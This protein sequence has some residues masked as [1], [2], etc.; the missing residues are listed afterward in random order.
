MKDK[1]KNK[2]FLH[3][4]LLLMVAIIIGCVSKINVTT[5]TTVPLEV[6][7]VSPSHSYYP[8]GAT[9]TFTGKGFKDGLEVTI[10]G[11]ACTGVAI[12]SVTQATCTAPEGTVGSQ[13][14]V[15][16]LDAQMV[17]LSNTFSYKT[18]T[19]MTTVAGTGVSG[20]TNGAGNVA[21][22]GT[23][24]NSILYHSTLQKFLIADGSNFKVRTLDAS[25]LVSTS[26]SSL[27]VTMADLVGSGVSGNLDGA[28]GV[29]RFTSPDD[30]FMTSS[31]LYLLDT[32]WQNPPYPSLIRE[33]NSSTGAA[34]TVKTGLEGYGSAV[35]DGGSYIYAAN[36]NLHVIVKIALSNWAVTNISGSSGVPGTADGTAAARFNCPFG[37]TID[38]TY[39]NL[40][41]VDYYN[42]LIRKLNIST[43]NVTTIAGDGVAGNTDSANG[44]LARFDA[45]S[46]LTMYGKYLFLTD[47]ANCRIRQVNTATTEV[48]TIAGTTCGTTDGT[49]TGTAQ[50]NQPNGITYHP[51]LGLMVGSSDWGWEGGTAAKTKIRLIRSN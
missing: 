11:Q 26:P 7:S 9:V 17:T 2:N 24:I 8:G 15:V 20:A 44:L 4:V 43:L 45:P 1:M 50:I 30:L 34:S 46:K 47:H 13:N 6:L 18:F 38:G 29:A 49:A 3:I 36:C 42:N 35:W 39:E 25:N 5:K 33:I 28:S 31:S 40:Y 51:T 22:V 19:H 37:L 41:I 48:T 32:D 23:Q 10:G 14:I 27:D 12:Q 16:A 21:Q